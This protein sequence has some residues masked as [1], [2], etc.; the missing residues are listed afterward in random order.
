MHS[1]IKVIT[2]GQGRGG[3]E[4][5]R[6]RER[7]GGG[8]GGGGESTVYCS[9]CGRHRCQKERRRKKKTRNERRRDGELFDKSYTRLDFHFTR[10]IALILRPKLSKVLVISSVDCGNR[11]AGRPFQRCRRPK[12]RARNWPHKLPEA[13]PKN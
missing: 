5:E 13:G 8:E 10:E 1:H 4:K 6:E 3:R 7:E 11:A 2:P 9:A 12:K